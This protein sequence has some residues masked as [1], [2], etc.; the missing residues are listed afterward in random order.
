MTVN[1]RSYGRRAKRWTLAVICA[2]LLAS[3]GGC[4]LLREGRAWL[5]GLEAYIYGFPLIM[6]DLTKEVSTAVPTAAVTA[7][8]F[9]APRQPVL[10]HDEVPGRLVQGGCEDGSRHAVRGGLGGPRQGTARAFGA[11]HERALLRHRA[12]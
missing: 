4:G 11:G 8:E 2:S 6:M 9:T 1:I 7:G 5:Y 3:A 12:L 10:R